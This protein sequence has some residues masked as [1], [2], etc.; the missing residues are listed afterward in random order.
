M[1]AAKVSQT[2][3]KTLSGLERPETRRRW[4]YKGGHV[5]WVVARTLFLVGMGFV[6]MYPL[7]MALSVAFRSQKD[8]LDPSVIWIP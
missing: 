6:L 3:K 7:L 5:L 4:L 8:L 1:S 2:V